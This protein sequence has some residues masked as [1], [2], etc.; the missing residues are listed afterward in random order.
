[1]TCNIVGLLLWSLK[2]INL[3]FPW[4]KINPEH[5]QIV[6]GG[7]IDSRVFLVIV[8]LSM[9]RM[10]EKN[11]FTEIGMIMVSGVEI[12]VYERKGE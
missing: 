3:G 2:K 5:I 7:V 11:V 12:Y 9:K 6:K 8:V 10:R 4:V 1:M